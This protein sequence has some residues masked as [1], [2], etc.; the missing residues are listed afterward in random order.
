VVKITSLRILLALAAIFDLHVH[1]MDVKTAF[2][3]GL[4]LEKIF[5]AQPEGYI[6]PKFKNK[7]CKL[8][9]SI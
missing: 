2:L 1:Q 6:N 8:L 4:I 9:K 7:V 5:M 3:Y